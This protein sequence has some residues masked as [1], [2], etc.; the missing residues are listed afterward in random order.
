MAEVVWTLEA[1][2]WLLKIHN[3]MLLT[4]PLTKPEHIGA[5]QPIPGVGRTTRGDEGSEV[6][7]R[8]AELAAIRR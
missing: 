5:L 8:K 2:R 4:A 6:D 7:W 1:E 3:Y